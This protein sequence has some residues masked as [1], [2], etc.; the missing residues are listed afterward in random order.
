MRDASRARLVER[1]PSAGR[2]KLRH[3]F[4]LDVGHAKSLAGRG[5][6]AVRRIFAD[7]RWP[8]RE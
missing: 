1:Q 4:A 5:E 7:E 8:L 6:G 2:R 3:A